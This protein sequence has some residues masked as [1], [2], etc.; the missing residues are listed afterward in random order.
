MA[1]KAVKFYKITEKTPLV[2]RKCAKISLNLRKWRKMFLIG[3][4]YQKKMLKLK[5]TY[6][7][8]LE[9]KL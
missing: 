3:Q 9:E 2:S 6:L 1:V 4:K 7:T 5:V 8:E